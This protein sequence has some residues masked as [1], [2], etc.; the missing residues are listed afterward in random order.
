M[1]LTGRRMISLTQRKYLASE[2]A[3]AFSHAQCSS[4]AVLPQTCRAFVRRS[5]GH[6]RHCS[7]SRPHEKLARFFFKRKKADVTLHPFCVGGIHNIDTCTNKHAG[8]YTREY[9]INIKQGNNQDSYEFDSQLHLAEFSLHSEQSFVFLMIDD[10]SVI[11]SPIDVGGQQRSVVH[12][13]YS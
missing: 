11:F 13:Q 10:Q 7:R 3:F 5:C 8:N 12:R 2:L 4:A 6:S 9:S 1:F